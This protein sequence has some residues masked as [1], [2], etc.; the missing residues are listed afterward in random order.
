M[1]DGS[2]IR[3]VGGVIVLCAVLGGCGGGGSS[4][5]PAADTRETSD[6]DR[7]ITQ[8]EEKIDKLKRREKSQQKQVTPAEVQSA[9]ESEGGASRPGAGNASLE[10][11]IAGA[12]G[13]LA[14]VMGA[15]GAEPAVAGGHLSSESAW[16]TMKVPIVLRVLADAGGAA[17]LSAGQSE[18]AERAITLS[19][20]AA[21]AALFAELE[22]TH[23]GLDGASAAVTEVL[24]EA[25]DGTTSVSTVGRDSFSTYGQTRWSPLLQYRFMAALAAGCVGAQGSGEYVLNL[26]SNA[27]DAWGFGGLGLLAAWKGGWGPGT[28]GRYLVRQ[29]GAVSVDGGTVVAT[30]AAIPADGRF[31]SGQAMVT[32]AARW[33]VEHAAQAGAPRPC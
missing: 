9:A 27:S 14:V 12:D 15:P 26:M 23:G 2:G 22:A 24:R 30:I 29:M 10:S 8:L 3:A 17:G 4:A 19:D 18:L 32:Q 1:K 16:S 28:D 5:T 31:E 20:N 11:L 13:E 25:G 7:Q 33:V 6:Q 21:A